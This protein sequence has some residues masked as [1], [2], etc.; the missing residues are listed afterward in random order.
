MKKF[1]TTDIEQYFQLTNNIAPIYT[2]EKVHQIINSPAAKARLKGKNKNLLKITIMTT[3][4]A[5]II[6]AFLF[7]TNLKNENPNDNM[8]ISK[9]SVQI[10]NSGLTDVNEKNK[11]EEDKSILIPDKKIKNIN[12][13]RTVATN[14][15]NK[16]IHAIDV[17]STQNANGETDNK[18]KIS[19]QP[20]SESIKNDKEEPKQ[21][22]NEI[23]KKEVYKYPEAQIPDSTFFIEL[24]REEF[25][26]F[27]FTIKD[28]S[29][30]LSYNHGNM[31]I[32]SKY[33]NG[34]LQ[35]DMQHSLHAPKKDSTFNSKKKHTEISNEEVNVGLILMIVTN[36]KGCNQ[37]QF[38]FQESLLKTWVSK[39][40]LGDCR[41]V[42][43]I[44]MKKHT[45]GNEPKEDVVFW[46]LP[47][48]EFFNRLPQNISKDI[49]SEYNYIT[50]EDKS[51]L[52]KPVCKYFDECKNT[53]A[54]SKFKVYPNPANN[55]ATISFTLPEAIDGRITLVDLSGRERQV[56]QPQ[57]NYSKGSH[58]FYVDVSSVPEGIYLLTLY[59]DKGVQT[60]RLIVAR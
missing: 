50:A 9:D 56:L 44:I 38:R 31:E 45:F 8:Q 6:S 22:A 21:Q 58:Q 29:I 25:E 35:F 28:S 1:E 17:D 16:N 34:R 40:F 3:L 24:N 5:V 55:T 23:R 39:K 13:V 19:D 18:N 41:T 59:S 2:E 48:D 30:K 33:I 27:G 4:F 46:F 47:T 53:L 43:P 37:I 14:E 51:Q 42:L 15:I 26:I 12:N 7:W 57:T 36:D 60:Q 52:E 54:V 10:V 20:N 11:V 32:F 49:L